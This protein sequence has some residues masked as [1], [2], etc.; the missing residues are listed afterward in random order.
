MSQRSGE[1][2]LPNILQERIERKLQMPSQSPS[3][4]VNYDTTTTGI[5]GIRYPKTN[6]NCNRESMSTDGAQRCL[7]SLVAN[8]KFEY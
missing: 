5:Q 8:L 2:I 6:G 3:E 4:S 1:D 7:R